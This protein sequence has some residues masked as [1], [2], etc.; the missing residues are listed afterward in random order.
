MNTRRRQLRRVVHE[1]IGLQIAPMI[2]VTLLLLFFFMLS[3]T[4]TKSARSKDIKLPIASTTV[5]QP[6]DEGRDV[7]HIDSSGAVFAGERRVSKAELNTL[8]RERFL[9]QPALRLQ[10]RADAGAPAA[11]IKSLVSAATSA[12]ALEIVFG[13]AKP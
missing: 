12:G 11:H 8:L 13:V 2:D 3:G 9:N 1:E 4:L 10:I 6:S 5:N 7:I